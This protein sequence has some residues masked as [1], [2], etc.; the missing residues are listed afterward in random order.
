MKLLIFLHVLGA[1]MFLGN[2]MTAAFWK[3]RAE[4]SGDVPSLN[5]IARNVMAADYAFTLPG[6][7]LL[8]ATGGWMAESAG[9][10]L[11]AWSWLTASL[12]L[13]LVTGLLWLLVLLPCQRQMIRESALSAA[14]GRM[15]AAYRKASRRWDIFGTVALLIPLLVLYLMTAKPF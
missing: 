14:E 5:R 4:V 9:Y 15:S 10:S 6:I 1:V 2:I 12:A 11:A 13:F 3:I 7:V 8:L